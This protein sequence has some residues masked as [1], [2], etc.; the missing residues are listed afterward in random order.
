MNMIKSILKKTFPIKILKNA[1]LVFNKIKIKT[2]D[3]LFFPEKLIAKNHF[4][5]L[6]Q[7]NP[8]LDHQVPTQSLSKETKAKLHLWVDPSW[9]QDQ[10]FLFYKEP[11]LIEPSCGWAITSTHHLIYASLGFARAPHV[12]KPSLME[13]YFLKKNIIHLP[14]VIS[15][16]DTGEE[17]Y[18]H[19]YNDVLAKLFFIQEQKF[20]LRDFTIIISERLFKKEFF[21]FFL[22]NSN[23]KDL[24]WHVQKDEWISF[25]S[26]IFCKPYTH[27]KKYLDLAVKLVHNASINQKQRRIFLTRSKNSL[28]FIENMDAIKSLLETYQFEI[29]DSEEIKVAAQI[30][31]FSSC[32]YLISIHGAG[33]TNIIFRQ[34]NPMTI[35]E[36]VQPSDYIPF[37]YIMLAHLYQYNYNIILGEKGLLH[38]QGGFR[39]NADQL[40]TTLEDMVKIQ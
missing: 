18:F 26:A 39:V 12:N 17:N 3:R 5:I 25:T 31:L 9:T 4:L 37:H 10:Y 13:S 15:L 33:L 2:W 22:N 19:F 11:A 6:E 24:H 35:L 38:Q 29:I 7:A 34:G 28:R 23:L 40:K 30:D 36:I 8:F 1:F 21:Q 27:T 16:R 20:N 32:R 14:N